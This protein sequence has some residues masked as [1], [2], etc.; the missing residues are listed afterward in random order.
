ML[1]NVSNDGLVRSQWAK[2]AVKG[3][4]PA[5]RAAHKNI[6]SALFFTSWKRLFVSMDADGLSMFERRSNHTPL[7]YINVSDLES[8]RIEQM[9]S[10]STAKQDRGEDSCVVIISTK[11]NDKIFIRLVSVL[12]KCFYIVKVLVN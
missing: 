10:G 4:G 7:V 2:V 12:L 5:K 11:L 3:N 1:S 9:A 8:V 6:F